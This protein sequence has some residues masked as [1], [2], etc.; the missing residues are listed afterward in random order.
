MAKNKPA[1]HIAWRHNLKCT[2]AKTYL[3]CHDLYTPGVESAQH[4]DKHICLS[5]F[6]RDYVNAM[7]GL[8]IEK[9]WVSRNGI[10]PERFK[11]RSII[12]KNP[13]KLVYPSSP[14]RGLDKLIVMLDKV[15][16]KH[17]VELH[18]F[19]GFDNLYKSGPKMVELADL[20]RK[21]ISERPWITYHGNTEQKELTRHLMEASLWVH[22]ANFIESFCITAIETICAGTYPI[23]RTLG[24]LKDTLKDAREKGFAFLFDENCETDQEIAMWADKV[25]EAIDNKVWEKISVDPKKYSWESVAREWCEEFGFEIKEKQS[26]LNYKNYEAYQELSC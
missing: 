17:P 10:V 11:D 4:F 7:Q 15:R 20:L 16:Q 8:P 24:A 3:W 23:T 21:M 19:Y 26:S 5:N 6:H 12:K 1:V 14:D 25:C 9:I 13:M 18:V 2:N 22:P